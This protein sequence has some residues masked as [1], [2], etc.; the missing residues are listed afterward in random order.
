MNRPEPKRVAHGMPA[1][2]GAMRFNLGLGAVAGAGALGVMIGV[3]GAPL[4]TGLAVGGA[5]FALGGVAG[6]G[7]LGPAGT[8]PRRLDATKLL[9]D[10]AAATRAILSESVPE[11]ER[12]VAAAKAI[13][14]RA[15]RNRVLGLASKANEIFHGLAEDP[16]RLSAV[17]RFLSYYLP[18][19]ANLAESFHALEAQT[20]PDAARLAETGAMIER[21]ESTFSDYQARLSSADVETLDMELKLLKGN[22]REDFG[23]AA[24][25]PGS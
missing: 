17:S 1:A 4:I 11:A 7:L 5:L 21:L 15:Q 19:A 6:A 9:T 16:E 22:L 14:D 24:N 3:I 13:R 2:R 8:K 18:I 23:P 20:P 25:E 12:L 10:Q